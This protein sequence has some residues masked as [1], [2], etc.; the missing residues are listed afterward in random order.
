MYKQ[1]KQYL[2]DLIARR[3]YLE[4][5]SKNKRS[6]MANKVTEK[7]FQ[8][9][10]KLQD[11]EYKMLDPSGGSEYGTDVTTQDERPSSYIIPTMNDEVE[12]ISL[13]MKREKEETK[14]KL[15]KAKELVIAA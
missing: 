7:I 5:Q 11:K 1:K 12:R 10:G 9:R 2:Q 15:L 3:N 4:E 14:K 8:R 6:E 13:I